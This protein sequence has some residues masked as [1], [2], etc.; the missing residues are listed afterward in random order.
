MVE[1]PECSEDTGS[2]KP[3]L[4]KLGVEDLILLKIDWKGLKAEI[5]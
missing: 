4:G 1:Q 5:T 3:S 2:D